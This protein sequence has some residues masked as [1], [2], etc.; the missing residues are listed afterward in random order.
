MAPPF[1]SRT[2]TL[3]LLVAIILLR[4]PSFFCNLVDQDEAHFLLISRMMFSGGIPFVDAVDKKPLFCYLFYSPASLFGFNM[5][6]LRVIGVL[7]VLVTCLVL[8]RA[9][10]A[11]SERYDVGLAAAW[12]YALISSCNNLA[13]HTELMMNLP[14]ALALYFFVRS[15]QG[16]RY[17]PYVGMGFS[18]SIA[19]LFRHQAGILLFALIPVIFWQ[20]RTRHQSLGRSLRYILVLFLCFLLPWLT[21]AC[22][23]AVIGHWAEFLEWNVIRNFIYVAKA[24]SV[25]YFQRFAKSFLMYVVVAAPV[26]WILAM[27]EATLKM[28]PVRAGL[29]LSLG[30]FWIPVSMGGRFWSQYFVQFAA[31]LALV[32]AP[33]AADL[34]R[35]WGELR[36]GFQKLLA[37]GTGLPVIIYLTVGYARLVTDAFPYPSQEVRTVVLGMFIQRNTSPEER[38]QV[39]GYIP[40]VYV[41]AKRLPGT[42]FISTAV[43]YG[44]IEPNHIPQ[45]FNPANALSL[46]DVDLMVA[47]LQRNRPALIIDTAPMNLN[48]WR[49]FPM[50]TAPLIMDYVRENYVVLPNTTG[51]RI[52]SLRGR[53]TVS[54]P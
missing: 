11:W 1:I 51:A 34:R 7:W 3:R 21:C 30:L 19:T 8:C 52:Y 26:P 33:Q 12:L 29:L 46:R 49:R 4:S 43:Q 47:D 23:Y 10:T 40:P 2:D 44:D 31:P 6:P 32:A 48:A 25:G 35:R 22:F 28:N 24:G 17:L 37:I 27:R 36:P 38:I 45:D 15:S 50:E 53:N 13:I 5:A 41:V 18:I 39:W 9:A 54:S 42:R 14:T 20:M 16:A